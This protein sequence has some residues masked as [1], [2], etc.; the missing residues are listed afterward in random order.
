MISLVVSL[1]AI[2]CLRKTLPMA[3][4]AFAFTNFVTAQNALPSGA[5]ATTAIE[6][7]NAGRVPDVNAPAP[8]DDALLKLLIKKGILT[9]EEARSA[10]GG[11]SLE[12]R[13]RLATL[14]RDKGLIT[15][16]EY[17]AVRAADAS[18]PNASPSTA[19]NATALAAQTGQTQTGQTQTGSGQQPGVQTQQGQPGAQRPEGPA[20]TPRPA[21]AN[22]IAAIAPIR[23]LQFEGARREGLIPDIKL[24]AG[25]R[26]KPYG[27]FKLSA[28]Q[29]SS[30]P[31]GNDFPLPG[32]IA[33]DTGPETSPEF[34][35]KARSFRFGANFEWLDPSPKYAITARFELD[36][37]GDFVRVANRNINSIRSGQPSLRLA[38]GRIDRTFNDKVTGFALFGQDWTPFGSST[39]PNMIETTGLGIGF[40]SLYQRAP[41][42]RTGFNFNAGTKRN[43]RFQPEFA[44]VL[45]ISGVTPSNVAEQLSIGERAGPDS[46]RPD[47]QGRFV[48]QFQLDKAA[49]VV[50]AQLIFSFLQGERRA[51]VTAAN[52]PTAFRAAFPRGAQID[53]D[54]YGYTAEAQLPTR[55]VTVVGKYYQGAD[56]RSYIG[57]Q[58]FSTFNDTSGLTNLAAA[59]SIDGATSV[60][61]G[62]DAS[63]NFVV[64]PQQPVRGKGGFIQL[65]FPLSRIFDADPKGRNAGWTAYAMYGYDDARASDVLR[66]SANGNRQKSDLFSANLQYKLNAFVTF[67]YEQ[68]LYRTRAIRG[69][70]GTLPLLRGIPSSETHNVRSEFATIFT[71]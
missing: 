19:I 44:L 38:W 61:F 49:G 14:L 53:S 52:V 6:G 42:I 9:T 2:R 18:N 55:F 28:V 57:T 50:P 41:Q 69:L 32:F 71:F 31:L 36:F 20:T 12:Q 37:E 54:R 46:N 65:G 35:L 10:A 5:G 59:A 22:V 70:N 40:G 64:A 24:A 27:F 26:I 47:I 48:T 16:A 67:A 60:A 43:L 13:L 68:S 8:D 7:A 4:A 56:L 51:I 62:T 17:E 3:F 1:A 39:L 11:S 58:L 15:A 23:A 45:P 34:R 25:A 66:I 30:S 33:A 21:A 63:G 29:D